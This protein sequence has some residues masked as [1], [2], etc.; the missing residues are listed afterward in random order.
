MAQVA[1]PGCSRAVSRQALE[2]PH[3]GVPVMAMLGP[4]STKM[5]PGVIVLL[6]VTGGFGMLMVLGI[7]AALVIPRVAA[8]R[9]SIPSEELVDFQE[10][11]E[12]QLPALAASDSAVV[13]EAIRALV[14]AYD[15]QQTFATRGS[16]EYATSLDDPSA[17]GFL[18]G[19]TDPGSRHYEF[20]VS[21]KSAEGSLCIEAVPTTSAYPLSIDG[22]ELVYYGL[23]CEG[24]PE[25]ERPREEWLGGE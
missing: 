15:L 3:C 16:G 17:P 4:Q 23:G 7:V 1:C 2:C 10:L 14:D 18:T 8:S 19:W 6:I 20:R 5:H 24:M 21:R 22:A 9:I 13:R 12:A 11:P 25:W